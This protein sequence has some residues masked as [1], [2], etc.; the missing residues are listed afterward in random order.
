[1]N[2]AVIALVAVALLVAAGFAGYWFGQQKDA[3]PATQVAAPRSNPASASVVVE[4]SKV[5]KAALPQGITA[6]GSL[7][8]DE[9]VTLRPEVAGRINSIHFHEGERVVKGAP[10]VK[11]DTSVTEAEER[12]A[13]ANL[14]WAKQKYQRALDLE[15]QGFISSQAKDEAENNLKVS[16]AALALAE[17]KLAKLTITAPFSGI[18]GLRSVS[19]GDYVKEGADMVNLEAI[20]PLKVDFRVPEVYLTQLRVGQTLELTLDA[21]PGKTYEGRLLAINPL[22]D[23]A[24]RSVVIRAQVKN[25]DAALRPGMFARVRLFTRDVQEALMVPEQ[26][27]VPQGEEWF[28]YRVVDGKAQ[29]AKVDIGQRRDGKAEIVKGLDAGDLVVTAGQLKL[30]EGVPVQVATTQRDATGAGAPPKADATP[31]PVPKS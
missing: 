8:S 9:S 28:V 30:R 23:A 15:K 25:Q 12:Q 13:R 19:V 3:G 21:M 10:L 17:A 18:I 26:A 27:I 7:R 31:A 1:M 29:R 6:V 5:A 24:G 16:E 2:K 22:I 11:L 14:T 20:D 4:A